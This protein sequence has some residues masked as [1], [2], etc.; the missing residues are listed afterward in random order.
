MSRYF[1][2]E[3]YGK[4]FS[5][6]N[7]KAFFCIMGLVGDENRHLFIFKPKHA[8]KE[9]IYQAAFGVASKEQ[10]NFL[11]EQ[12]AIFCRKWV[13]STIF[14]FNCPFPPPPHWFSLSL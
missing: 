2:Q 11:R 12:K 9:L 6:V 5:G 13:V 4:R 7:P 1:V 8:L 10:N 3:V 14:T